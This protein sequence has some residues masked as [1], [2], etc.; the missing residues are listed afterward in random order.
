MTIY[1]FTTIEKKPEKKDD[2][3]DVVTVP[4]TDE[5]KEAAPQTPA[6]IFVRPRRS[7][8]CANVIV[9]FL[10]LV[11]MAAGIIGGIYL[12]RHLEHKATYGVYGVRY[13]DQSEFELEQDGQPKSEY[14]RMKEQKNH[15]QKKYRYMS[16]SVEVT[17]NRLEKIEVPE[18]DECEKALVLH[19]FESNFTAIVDRDKQRCFVMHLN[20]TLVAPPKDWIDLIWKLR[21]GYYVPDAV[22]VR[23][24]YRVRIPPMKDLSELGP[25][26]AVECGSLRTYKLERIVGNRRVWKRSAVGTAG[27]HGETHY[28]GF[29][30]G[31]M[32]K[33]A[34]ELNLAKFEIVF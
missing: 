9:V 20:R 5:N 31:Q 16:E 22:I 29:L 15:K 13:Y 6:Y 8:A 3:A 12:Y 23:H 25:N 19:D 26:I 21:S 18:F 28:Y 17:N 10:A 32:D 7:R 34:H 11:V 33:G 27:V 2:F 14:H 24:K 30:G 4:L 1:K